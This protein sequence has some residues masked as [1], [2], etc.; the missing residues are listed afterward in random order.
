V[1]SYANIGFQPKSST[2]PSERAASAAQQI[3]FKQVSSFSQ[4]G[5]NQTKIGSTKPSRTNSSI[6]LAPHRRNKQA[7]TFKS[8]PA[9]QSSN[10]ASTVPGRTNGSFAPG[11]S[12][13]S[14][15]AYGVGFGMIGGNKRP[16]S[17]ENIFKSRDGTI[18][19]TNNSGVGGLSNH[20]SPTSAPKYEVINAQ[21]ISQNVLRAS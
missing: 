8:I 15:A 4:L 7:S 10:H 9:F 16:T 12:G 11:V 20:F 6:G 2:K 14:T 21:Q 5:S 18:F 1:S 19:Q 3:K 17:N 13:S